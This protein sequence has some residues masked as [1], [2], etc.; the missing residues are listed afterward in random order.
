[1]MIYWFWLI[2]I[3]IVVTLL[4]SNQLC[5]SLFLD[6]KGKSVLITGCGT[7]FGN[8]LA[9]YLDKLGVNVYAC[10]VLQSSAVSL[11][12]E[13]SPRLKAFMLDVTDQTSV[14]R[15]FDIVKQDLNGKGLWAVVNN[16]AIPAAL[17]PFDWTNVNDYVK[18]FDVNL[19]GIIRMTLTFLPLI[20]QGKKGRIINVSSMNGR[21]NIMTNAYGIAK[22]G[23][24]ALS[25]GLSFELKPFHITVHTIQPSIFKTNISN[26]EMHCEMIWNKW[27]QVNDNVKAEYGDDYLSKK[28]AVIKKFYM[29]NTSSN[30]DCVVEAYIHALFAKFPCNR[31]VVGWDAKLLYLPLSWLPFPVLAVVLPFL[32]KLAGL[33]DPLPQCAC[34][35]KSI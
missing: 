22:C 23:L 31:Y 14:N 27:V 25:D 1:M 28:L 13:C 21:L 7:G 35:N 19:I 26:P 4:L 32:Q 12:E 16:A 17:V 11:N 5:K 3:L 2:L 8:K 10:C 33:S 18:V 24:E 30:L 20:K 34:L 15:A 29:K 6:V 9:K